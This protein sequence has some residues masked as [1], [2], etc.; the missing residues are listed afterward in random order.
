M[1]DE[2]H[3]DIEM[4]AKGRKAEDIVTKRCQVEVLIN[5]QRGAAI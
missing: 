5:L 4:A 1:A 3:D 2:P